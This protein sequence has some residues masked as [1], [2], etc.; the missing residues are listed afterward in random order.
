[1]RMRVMFSKSGAVLACAE[2]NENDDNPQ[3]VLDDDEYKGCYVE[4][5]EMPS[6]DPEINADELQQ[7]VE[8]ARK[9]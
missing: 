3:F 4:D 1:M 8:N 6:L 5:L 9:K 2:I 7:L